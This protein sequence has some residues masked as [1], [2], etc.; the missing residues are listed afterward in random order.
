MSIAVST[1][2][3]VKQVSV[4]EELITFHLADGRIVS[5]PLAWSW[6]LSDATS[7]QRA[8]FEI[9]GDGHGVHWPDVD[10]DLSV[11]GMLHGVPARRPK[12]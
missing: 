7:A 8:N 10:E 12:K 6:R 3:R 9:I 1:D 11:E 2:S 4:T 5:V